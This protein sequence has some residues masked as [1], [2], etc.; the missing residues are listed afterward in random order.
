M[1]GLATRG[2]GEGREWGIEGRAPVERD[3]GTVLEVLSG[4]PHSR[5]LVL[6]P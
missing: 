3:G 6:E 5:A 1:H 4:T 2:R